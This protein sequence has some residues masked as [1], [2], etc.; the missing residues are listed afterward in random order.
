MNRFLFPPFTNMQRWCCERWMSE[1]LNYGLEFH[2]LLLL[3]V[4]I[5]SFSPTILTL[6]LTLTLPQIVHR[7]WKIW[8]NIF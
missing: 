2:V 7:D 8:C 6:K 5:H 4:K 1:Y 3:W